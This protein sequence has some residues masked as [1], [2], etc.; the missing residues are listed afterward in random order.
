[1][2]KIIDKPI[3]Y[4]RGFDAMC[5]TRILRHFDNY[6]EARQYVAAHRRTYVRYWLVKGD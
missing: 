3:D 4:A 5:G 6:A 2:K 1:M